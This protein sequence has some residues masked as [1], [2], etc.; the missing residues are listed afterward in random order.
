MQESMSSTRD[1]RPRAAR[2]RVSIRLPELW[3]H[4]RRFVDDPAQFTV[5]RSATKC[6]KTM[7]TAWWVARGAA[8]NPGS[9]WWWVGPTNDVGLI[10]YKTIH[11]L[12]EAAV[13]R[14]W[15]RPF[16]FRLKT[17]ATVQLKSAQEPEYLRGAGVMGMGL[18]EAG[19]PTFDDAWP[20]IRTTITATRGRLK[21]IG[22]PGDPGSFFDRAESWGADP[23]M[24]EWSFHPWKFMD[25]PTATDADLE[26]AKRELGEESPEFRRYY[27]GETVRGD[28]AFFY[29]VDKVCTGEP[30]RPVAGER[31]IMGVDTSGSYK[32]NPDYF[33]ATVFRESQ[34][35]QV[36][37]SR[38]RGPPSEVQADEICRLAK[39]YNDAI[40]M[41]EVNGPGGPI[42][43]MCRTRGANAYAFETQTKSKGVGLYDYRSDISTRRITLL[44]DTYQ[45]R[46]HLKFQRR[47]TGWAGEKFGA[48]QGEHDDI[49]MANMI[50]AGAMRRIVTPEVVWVC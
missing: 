40:V 30:E 24:P 17:G 36:H 1:G 29:G 44:N 3:P 12:L 41:I 32:A 38:H 13:A 31:Y 39:E 37:Y 6:G 4:Q 35:R 28:G 25:R 5:C 43:Q 16:K 45:L 20:E 22:N 2:A 48:P 26:Q 7:A 8:T 14:K 21:I 33:V 47:Q 50:A 34:R 10:G 46:E 23:E 15:E 27:L 42:W 9:L 19:T 49:V 11:H 18:D